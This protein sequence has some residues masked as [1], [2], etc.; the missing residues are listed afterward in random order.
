MQEE[1][2]KLEKTFAKVADKLREKARFGK[3]NNPEVLKQA[4]QSADTI[5]LYRPKH[6]AS[7]FEPN[8]VLYEGAFDRDD[9]EKFVN[10]E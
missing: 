5:V 7:K 3:T 9:I 10:K 1:D 6:L 8:S 4:G 2:S